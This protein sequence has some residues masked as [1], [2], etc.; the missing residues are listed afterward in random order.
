MVQESFPD[1]YP[2][3]K[4]LLTIIVCMYGLQHHIPIHV[5]KVYWSDPGDQYFPFFNT[6]VSVEASSSFF[7]FVHKIYIRLLWTV[8]TPY[9]V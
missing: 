6:I 4:K 1:S 2:D 8:V 7:L 5:Y 3:I 9:A